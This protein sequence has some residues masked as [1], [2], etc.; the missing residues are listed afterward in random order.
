[1][2]SECCKTSSAVLEAASLEQPGRVHVRHQ[3]LSVPPCK[4]PSAHSD[5][6]AP[7][8]AQPVLYHANHVKCVIGL[9]GRG[10]RSDSRLWPWLPIRLSVPARIALA[11]AWAVRPGEPHVALHRRQPCA[12]RAQRPDKAANTG[13]ASAALASRKDQRLPGKQSD[14]SC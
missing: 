7:Q 4:H 13:V 9:Q 11:Y 12:S 1:M 8:P 3:L 10:C 6:F 14:L 2:E 5:R